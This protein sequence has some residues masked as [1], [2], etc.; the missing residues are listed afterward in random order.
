MSEFDVNLIREFERRPGFYDRNSPHFKDKIYNAQAWQDI[1][2]MLGYDVALLKDRMLQLRNRYNLEKRRLENLAEEYPTKII[3]SQWPL[4]EHLHFL[5]THIRPRRS[6]KR[7]LTRPSAEF[8]SISNQSSSSDAKNFNAEGMATV[9]LENQLDNDD[10]EDGNSNPDEVDMDYDASN[11]LD[12]DILPQV[13]TTPP[14]I[15]PITVKSIESMRTIVPKENIRKIPPYD[16]SAFRAKQIRIESV[17]SQKFDAFG[18]FMTSS[19]IEMPPEKA[20]LLVEK[21]TS[22]IVKVLIEKNHS[23]SQNGNPKDPVVVSDD[24]FN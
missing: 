15:K 3:Q 22:D 14:I 5:S 24:D 6:Y 10:S 18:K 9:K 12:N 4:Y 1:S 11:S 21:F 20:L 16:P 17:R 23:P 2:N 13:T 19:L 7:M 8:H